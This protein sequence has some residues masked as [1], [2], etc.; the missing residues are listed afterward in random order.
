M[1]LLNAYCMLC[2]V[3]SAGETVLRRADKVLSHTNIMVHGEDV[4]T[5]MSSEAVTMREECRVQQESKE[6]VHSSI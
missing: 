6:G 5:S 2:I 1:Y 4:R 3:Q